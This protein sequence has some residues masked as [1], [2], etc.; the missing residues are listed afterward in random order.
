MTNDQIHAEALGLYEAH[1]AGETYSR[2]VREYA[3]DALRFARD[4]RGTSRSALALAKARIA[5]DRA[6]Y[7]TATWD[8]VAAEAALIEAV[9]A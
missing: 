7:A 6:R 3:G 8:D 9:A 1:G 2:P 4:D 5:A